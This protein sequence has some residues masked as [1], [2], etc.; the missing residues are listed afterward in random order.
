ML[1]EVKARLQE[2][3]AAPKSS[4]EASARQ[5]ERAEE[6]KRLG[7]MLEQQ[8]QRLDAQARRLDAMEKSLAQARRGAGERVA[9][10]RTVA[11][12]KPATR[13]APQLPRDKAGYLAFAR[14]QEL[15]GDKTVAREVYEQ[16]V[17]EFPTDPSSAEAHF[18][19]GELAFGERRYRDAILQFG[20]VAKDFPRSDQAPDALLRTGESMLRLDMKD[21]AV[22]VL[23]EVPQR[24]PGTSAATRAKKR[25]SELPKESAAATE[26]RK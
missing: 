9:E 14:E 5:A 22:A 25:L 23:S 19:L 18:R 13:E 21:E 4:A 24:Y 15:K 26:K 10:P 7:A 1:A 11:P 6:L 20:K 2:L 17:V 12:E 8:S 16:Y 3:E